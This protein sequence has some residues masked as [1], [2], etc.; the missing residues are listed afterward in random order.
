[1]RCSKCGHDNKEDAKVCVKCKAD[2]KS[3]LI[4]EPTWKWHLKVLAIIYAILGIAYIL[5]RI[6]LKD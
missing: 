4:E 1:M 6:F 3:I 5:L 2:L